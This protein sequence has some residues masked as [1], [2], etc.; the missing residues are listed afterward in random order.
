MCLLASS[1]LA[2]SPVNHHR[3]A[4]AHHALVHMLLSVLPAEVLLLRPLPVLSTDMLL[5]G[6]R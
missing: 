2:D 4:P 3:C 1:R 6:K 5:P